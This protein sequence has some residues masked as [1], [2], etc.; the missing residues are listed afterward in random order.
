MATRS[1]SPEYGFVQL[2]IAG[3]IALAGVIGNVRL[4]LL[5]EWT[6]RRAVAPVFCWFGWR[7]T[8]SGSQICWM[9]RPFVWDPTGGWN[10]SALSISTEVSLKPYGSGPP[11][12]IILNYLTWIVSK[13]N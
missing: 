4:Q 11:P 7:E 10:S 12:A 6:G 2:T 1:P 5:R 8:P 13:E 3:F 9:L